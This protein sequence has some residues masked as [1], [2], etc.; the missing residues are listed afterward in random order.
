MSIASRRIVAPVTLAVV[1]FGLNNLAAISGWLNPPPA[2][3]ATLMARTHDVALYLGL[4]N[5]FAANNLVPSY[6]APWLIEP[7]FFNPIQWMLGRVSRLTGGDVVVV[8]L[9]FHFLSYVLA[10]AAL[11]FAVRT[12]TTSTRQQWA[13]FGVLLCIVPL[14]SLAVL[15]LFLAGHAGPPIGAGYFVWLSSDGFFHGISGSALVT[16]GTATTLL[17][18]TLLA[19]YLQTER[20]RYFHLAVLT[21]FVSAF[22]HATEIFLIVA[23]GTIALVWWRAGAWTRA[24]PEIG[25]LSAAGIC[26]LAPYA[27]MTARQPWLRELANQSR[28]QLPGGPHEILLM[29]GLPAAAVLGCLVTRPTMP[30]STDRLLQCWFGSTL[31]GIYLPLMP[32][33]QH[34]FDGFHYAT[35]L[36]LVRQTAQSAVARRIYN[37]RPRLVWASA[38]GVFVLS[39][40]AYVA[41]YHQ[42]Y[43][44]GRAVRPE[45]LFSTVA[46]ND[47]RAV[48]SWLRQSAAENQLVLA[49]P[50]TAPWLMAVPMHS[51]AGHWHW[52]LTYS[53]Q[54]R[55]ADDFYAGALT[56]EAA[57]AMLTDYGIRYVV[58]PE[59]TRAKAYLT[60]YAERVTLGA[61]TIYESPSLSMRPYPTR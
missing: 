24:L 27:I 25:L 45:R 29:L 10:A 32:S 58:V 17:A 61:L 12:F 49:P 48:V 35:A 20:K 13:V 16:F 26:G 41:Y 34:L 28:W 2:H 21:A 4:A 6:A 50:A 38:V 43:R 57:R 5:G 3:A 7:A 46:P 59:G 31:V 37:A 36:L 19:R 14:P 39:L 54:A 44:D 23:A 40:S 56:P 47:E 42:S 52:S 53:E 1:L 60:G 33:P 9:V 51:F 8:Y 15:P 11:F 22:A 18:F 30:A 55:L